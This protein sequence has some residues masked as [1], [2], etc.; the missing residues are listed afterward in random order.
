[1]PHEVFISH[2]SE[3]RPLAHAVC[4]A[5]EAS[6]VRCWIAPRDITPSQSWAAAITNA[7][8]QTRVVVLVFT[9]HANVSKYVLNEVTL[10][11]EHTRT[12]VPFR[13]EDVELGPDLEFY[14]SSRH[15]LDALTPPIEAHIATLVAD[16]HTLLGE[17]IRPP[18]QAPEP[19]VKVPREPAIASPLT[20]ISPDE[21]NRPP[22]SSIW[23][24]L[25]RWFE[26]S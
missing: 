15:W 26:E 16:V 9:A 4:A 21:W 22:S 3:D 12:I 24:R 19:P 1:M 17:P 11:V 14:L 5:L 18:F 8:A 2:S 23:S 13:V 6:G 7:I 20:E 25:S 10:A